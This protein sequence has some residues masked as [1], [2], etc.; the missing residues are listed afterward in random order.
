MVQLVDEA[1][2]VCQY[3][4]KFFLDRDAFLTEAA[5]YA[6]RFP[7]L[8][9]VASREVAARADALQAEACDS[10]CLLQSCQF[11]AGACL[12]CE[13]A[14]EG[15]SDPG[16]HALPPCIVTDSG[17]SLQD[18]LEHKPEDSFSTVAVSPVLVTQF[19]RSCIP[20][21]HDWVSLE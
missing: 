16:G 17:Q 4:V 1:D 10:C 12:I 13:E 9:K 19:T 7:A 5:L 14:A 18:W 21:V 11:M 8:R 20:P 15:L 6:A 2:G 3:A